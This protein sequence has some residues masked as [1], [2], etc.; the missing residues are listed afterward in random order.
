MKYESIHGLRRLPQFSG[1][2]DAEF[3]TWFEDLKL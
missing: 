2:K 3:L 1:N